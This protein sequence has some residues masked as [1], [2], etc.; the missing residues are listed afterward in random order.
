M[1]SS[2]KSKK[3][4]AVNRLFPVFLKLDGMRVLIV[5][6]GKVAEEKVTAI[7]VNSPSTS[8]RMVSKTF[9]PAL[10][11]LAS[12]YHIQLISKSFKPEDLD[13]ADI[14]FSAVNDIPTSTLIHTAAREQR[15]LHNAADKPGLC[16]FY[17]GSVVQRGNLKIGISTN[18][19]SPTIAKRLKEV[20]I[21]ALPEEMDQVLDQ[22]STIRNSL[23][24]GLT[25]KIKRLNAITSILVPER[26]R[27]KSRKGTL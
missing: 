10:R 20:L 14:V 18:G 4:E 5:G 16:D 25:E 2:S 7:L 15:I 26:R 21:D 17:L 23:R 8:V 13:W 24:G 19:K 3:L 9:T 1:R 22:L 27:K 12:K 11:K 6:G